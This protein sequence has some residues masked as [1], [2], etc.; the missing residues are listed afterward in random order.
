[1]RGG[2]GTM[3]RTAMFAGTWLVAA[4]VGAPALAATQDA[5]VE[6]V[7]AVVKDDVATARDRA[8]DDAKRKA[9]EQIAGSQVSSETITENFQLVEDK[10]YARASGFVKSYQILSEAK[11]EGVYRVKIKATVDGGAIADNLEQLFKAKPRVIVMIA[12]QNI[13]SKGFSYWW[14]NSGFV[15]DMNIMQNSLIEEWQPRGYK[16]I[17]PALMADKLSIKGPMQNPGIPDD[18]AVTVSKDADAD[19]VIVGK[20]LVSDA[21]QVM[22]GVKMHSFHA[23]GTLR[24]LN[25]D[26]GEI[27]AVADDTGVAANI[28]PNMGGRAAIKALAKK[29]APD[30]ERKIMTKWTAEAASARD[31]DVEVSGVKNTKIQKELERVLKDEIRGVEAVA[32]RKKKKDVVY[33]SVKVRASAT[34]LA[35]DLENKSWKDFTVDVDDVSRGKISL[36]VGK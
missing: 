30:L 12:E 4:L 25:T 34:D 13:G 32:V 8:I 18:V 33:L 6:G 11:E 36:K 16:F 28:D 20:V 19:I 10:I 26:T 15:S 2:R 29:L 35:H 31:V 3:M 5:E 14:G 17:D 9:V 21:G 23:V 1:M 7:A 27:V 22:D 24:I